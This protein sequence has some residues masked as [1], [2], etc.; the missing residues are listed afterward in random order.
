MNGLTDFLLSVEDPCERLKRSGLP[1]Y[2]YGTGDGADKILALLERGGVKV[3][4]VFA[5]DGFVRERS[6]H[7]FRVESLREVEAREGKIAAVLCFGL[8]P[9]E[10]DAFR[11]R[12]AGH[13][14]LAP[15]V[16]VFGETLVDHAFVRE[17]R[18]QLER[19]EGWLSDE[20]SKELFRKVLAYS[21]S[22]DPAYLLACGAEAE[23][24]PAAYVLHRGE[25]IDV[26]AFDGDTALEFLR[27][28]P[29]CPNVI[30]FEPDRANFA[31]LCRNTEGFPVEPVRGAVSDRMGGGSFAG[32]K[33]RGSALRS[34]EG[35][36]PVYT[37]DGFCG[38]PYISS[39]GRPVGGIKIDAEGQDKEVLAGASN[40]ITHC[41]PVI[42]VS[43]YHR[44]ED[45][46]EIPLLL[47]RL[48]YRSQLFFRKKRCIPAW[49]TVF[50]AVP[51]GNSQL[52]KTEDLKNR[53]NML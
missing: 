43:A 41:R 1:V 53:K 25:H 2:L 20:L 49:D 36:T 46:V 5:S 29:D 47:K 9:E 18:E 44:G 15:A 34:G 24:A 32:N 17:H 23:T 6:F 35:E 14:F 30:A 50:Y 48:D 28:N 33:G 45:L 13:L 7:G 52:F 4:G 16:P 8:E 12:L 19:V 42:G 10:T 26:G 3:E 31:K 51:E 21:V 40:L 37:L 27:G 11:E 39:D 38:Y 22:G